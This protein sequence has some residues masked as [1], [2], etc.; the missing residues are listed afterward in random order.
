MPIGITGGATQASSA[1]TYQAPADQNA[2]T[3]ALTALINVGTPS[4]LAT[5]NMDGTLTINSDAPNTSFAAQVGVNL[6][7]IALSSPV[8]FLSENYGPISCPTNALTNILTPIAGWNSVTNLIAGTTGTLTETDAELRIRRANSTKLLGNCTV[9]AIQ[10][11]LKQNVP[12]VTSA[13]VFENRTLTQQ[14]YTIVFASAFAASDV[15]TVFYNDSYNFTVTCP[16]SPNQV[17]SMGLLVAAFETLPEVA[18]ASY[19]GAGNQTLTVNMLILN[20]LILNSVV[21]SVSAQTATITGGRPPKSF[22]AVVQR[23][24]DD[25]VANQIWKSKPAGIETYGNTEID[26]T[27]SQGDAHRLLLKADGRIHFRSSRVDFV[28]GRNVPDKWLAIGSASYF[29]LWFNSWSWN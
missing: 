25:A 27:D 29:Q 23:G 6:S 21:T 26:I 22:E 9:D 14:S 11:Q 18:S 24:T 13:T 28:H 12:G 17:T 10:A 7:I 16:G 5:D 20:D 3:A 8:T 15:V 19:G 1:L 4:W 2:I